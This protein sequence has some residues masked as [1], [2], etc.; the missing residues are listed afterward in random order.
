MRGRQ[1]EREKE[2]ERGGGREKGE[3]KREGTI[4]KLNASHY[5]GDPARFAPPKK[6][7]RA[8]AM[9]ADVYVYVYRY[10][11]TGSGFVKGNILAAH[12]ARITA[13]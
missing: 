8:S 4:L 2:R 3:R 7:P 6:R 13:L 5:Y 11:V 1:R 9:P 10:A 12:L